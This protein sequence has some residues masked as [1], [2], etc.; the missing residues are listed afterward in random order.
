MKLSVA[1]CPPSASLDRSGAADDR[2]RFGC[3]PGKDS[4]LED[5]FLIALAQPLKNTAR[6]GGSAPYPG[7]SK[8]LIR[9]AHPRYGTDLGVRRIG[10]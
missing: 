8:N 3:V 5:S 6:L 4:S 1:V 10:S 9:S 7:R 2:I